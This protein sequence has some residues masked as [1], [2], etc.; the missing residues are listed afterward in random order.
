AKESVV[1]LSGQIETID[2]KSERWKYWERIPN[3]SQAFFLK[4]YDEAGGFV[5]LRMTVENVVFC[6][7]MAFKKIKLR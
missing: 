7:P 5:V 1:Y 6:K 2:G 3:K 4:Y